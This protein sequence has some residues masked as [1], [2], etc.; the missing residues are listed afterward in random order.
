MKKKKKDAPPEKPYATSQSSTLPFFK[1]SGFRDFDKQ[2]PYD[3]STLRGS[4]SAPFDPKQKQVNAWRERAK[5]LQR[6]KQRKERRKKQ[7]AHGFYSGG[8]VRGA[9]CARQGVRKVKMV[10]MNGA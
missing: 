1:G 7:R 3:P 4:G 9:G 8:K 2:Q 6:E 10:T 5:E